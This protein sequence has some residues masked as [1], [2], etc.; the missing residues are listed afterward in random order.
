MLDDLIFYASRLGWILLEPLNLL[1]VGVLAAAWLAW[2]G[3]Q[4][5]LRRLLTVLA[6]VILG[7]T[8]LPLGQ[9][10]VV[11]LEQRFPPPPRLPDRVDGIVMLGGAQI[12]RL[13]AR[14]GRPALNDAAERMTTFVAL[15][16]AYPRARLVFTG[17]SGDPF[18]QDLTETETVRL[19]L[20]EQ[21]ID[22]ARV[23]FEARSR[24]TYENAVLTRMMVRPRPAETWLLVTSALHL[25]RA[26]GAFRAAGWRVQPVPCDYLTLPE[27]DW[28]PSLTVAGSFR[29][30]GL[31][32]HEWL[33]LAVYYAA[34]RTDALFPGPG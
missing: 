26:M 8:L 6:G 33:G 18:R 11:P 19:F 9:A 22:P 32:V 5:A 28:A 12:P 3:R 15:A 14:Y 7:A 29:L 13:T 17:G 23:S 2:R 20:Q 27:L 24:N 4:R 34:G 31:G 1:A 10:L 30:L 16:R 21:G 25:P